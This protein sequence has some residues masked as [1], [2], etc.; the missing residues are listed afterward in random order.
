MSLNSHWQGGAP[1]VGVGGRVLF[2]DAFCQS[3]EKRHQDQESTKLNFIM[4]P[5]TGCW[6]TT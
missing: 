6:T 3:F 4:L 1:T 5:A 2:G